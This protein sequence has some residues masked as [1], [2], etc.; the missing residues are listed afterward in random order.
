MILFGMTRGLKWKKIVV[1]AILA[2]LLTFSVSSLTYHSLPLVSFSFFTHFLFSPF[3]FFL[4]PLPSPSPNRIS[5][6]IHDYVMVHF[7]VSKKTHR[8][9]VGMKLEAIDRKNPDLICVATVTNVIGN[10]FLVHF[11]EWDDTYDYWCQDDCPYIHPIGW[12]ESTGRKLN[13]P[14]GNYCKHCGSTYCACAVC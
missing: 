8:F 5:N 1:T 4:F 2:L 13:P 14:N 12:C 7:K 9:E 6:S 10:Y 3:S 11:D